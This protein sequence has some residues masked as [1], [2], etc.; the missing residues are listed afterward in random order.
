VALAAALEQTASGVEGEALANAVQHIGEVSILRPCITH[1]TGRHQRQPQTPR[2]IDER[3]VAMLLG[4]QAMTL[5]LDMQPV[6]ED[7]E[8]M[9]ELTPGGVEAAVDEALGNYSFGAAG[10]AEQTVGVGFD[11]SPAGAG[12]ALGPAARR[13]GEETTEVAIAP[14]VTREK[15]EPGQGSAGWGRV[16]H[17]SQWTRKF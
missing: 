5:E 11:L 6:G 10:E 2:E 12:F 3:L 9:L 4:A 13:F 1:S 17:Q 15:R 7:A 8:Q 16:R 14:L